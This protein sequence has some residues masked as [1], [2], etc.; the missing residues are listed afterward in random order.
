MKTRNYF[1]IGITCA[2]ISFFVANKINVNHM[3]DSVTLASLVTLAYA[4]NGTDDNEND[5]N[6]C[7][8]TD[9]TVENQMQDCQGV[10]VL[11]RVSFIYK[12]KGD[13]PGSSARNSLSSGPYCS[14]SCSSGNIPFA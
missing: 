7:C 11:G 10:N 5:D 12:C 8:M 4:E 9:I 13:N 2:I 3:S 6:K 1:L 14:G